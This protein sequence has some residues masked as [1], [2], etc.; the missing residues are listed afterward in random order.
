MES[1][2]KLII[3]TDGGS[4]GNPGQ[5]ALGVFIADDKGKELFALG[6]RIGVATNN[7]AEYSAVVAAFQWIIEHKKNS[8]VSVSFF[9]DSL[10]VVSQLNGV[11]KIKNKNLLPLIQSIQKMQK[12]LSGPVRFT[13][14]P[15]EKNKKADSLVNLALDN[16]L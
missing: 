16:I 12:T 3:Y 15:R 4:R 10:L 8:L 1:E 11:W 14:I 9:M 7:I 2:T 5:A 13:H 6:K